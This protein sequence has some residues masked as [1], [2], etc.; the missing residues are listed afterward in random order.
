MSNLINITNIE[1]DTDEEMNDLPTNIIVNVSD[2]DYLRIKDGDDDLLVD[3]VSDFYNFCIN[4]LEYS[5]FLPEGEFLPDVD[6][7]NE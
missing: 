6:L 2:E 4:H 7:D 1:W 3:M 5:F